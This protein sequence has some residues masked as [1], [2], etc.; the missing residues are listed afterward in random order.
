MTENRV[1]ISAHEDTCRA[2]V[3]TDQPRSK[4]KV[5]C[6]LAILGLKEANLFN[7]NLH[8]HIYKCG[9]ALLNP[10]RELKNNPGTAL[11][12][13]LKGIGISEN[14]ECGC[15]AYANS[16]DSWGWEGC[17]QRKAEIIEHLNA[18][19]VSWL[20]MIKVA[21]AGYFTTESLVDSAL[22]LSNP[23]HT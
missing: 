10:T 9:G 6:G 11:T 17:V 14:S 8:A 18:Q 13:I 16:M 4:N 19:Q 20:D 22:S 21:A 1:N 3:Q 7:I 5:T 12:K 15:T 23:N 2:C